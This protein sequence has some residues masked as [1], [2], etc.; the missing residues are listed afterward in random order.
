[1]VVK[2]RETEKLLK[3]V[4]EKLIMNADVIEMEQQ[5]KIKTN[6]HKREI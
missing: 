3:K 1:M 6:H 5:I 2:Y 4:Q